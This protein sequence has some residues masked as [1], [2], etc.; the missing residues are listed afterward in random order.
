MMGIEHTPTEAGGSYAEPTG[1]C[2]IAIVH[3]HH[4]YDIHTHAALHRVG[5]QVHAVVREAGGQHGQGVGDGEAWVGGLQR[6]GGRHR[7]GRR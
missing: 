3:R 6:K 4:I 7:R 1:C 5:Q 2:G